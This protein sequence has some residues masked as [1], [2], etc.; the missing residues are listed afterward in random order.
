MVVA[1][2]LVGRNT[3]AIGTEY[4]LLRTVTAGSIKVILV[5][6]GVCRHNPD[7]AFHNTSGFRVIFIEN[8]VGSGD[9]NG[10]GVGFHPVHKCH[11]RED[12]IGMAAVGANRAILLSRDGSL[13]V[14]GSPG[15]GCQHRGFPGNV[16]IVEFAALE[17]AVPT[18]GI[19]QIRGKAKVKD[20]N[21]IR[22]RKAIDRNRAFQQFAAG[23]PSLIA[24]DICLVRLGRGDG[25]LCIGV[26]YRQAG[27]LAHG[28]NGYFLA[29]VLQSVVRGVSRF[30]KNR[31]VR[32]EG[33]DRIGKD[34]GDAPVV[35]DGAGG[36]ADTGLL[37]RGI[38]GD[39][40]RNAV[41]CPG[42]N[43]GDDSRL[44]AADAD[45]A[46]FGGVDNT[47]RIGSRTVGVL[48]GVGQI[49][50]FPRREFIFGTVQIQQDP[51]AK[52]CTAQHRIAEF[53]GNL[54]RTQL[55]DVAKGDCVA[56]G[57]VGTCRT[58][59]KLRS[60][61]CRGCQF[62]V[63]V[64]GIVKCPCGTIVNILEYSV[65]GFHEL[66]R[67]TG[68]ESILR[69]VV[70]EAVGIGVVAD[71]ENIC[72]EYLRV[73]TAFGGLLR[74][75]GFGLTGILV[76]NGKLGEGNAGGV[77]AGGGHGEIIIRDTA[78]ILQNTFVDICLIQ[79]L[80]DGQ[81]GGNGDHGKL[82]GEVGLKHTPFHVEY[83]HVV[84]FTILEISQ[85]QFAEFLGRI[86]GCQNS[87][88]FGIT[89]VQP[90]VI[91]L[92]SIT[93]GLVGIETLDH[94]AVCD[95]AGIFHR[96]G[97]VGKIDC[98]GSHGVSAAHIQNQFAIDKDPN[99]IVAGE[100][101]GDGIAGCQLSVIA[102]GEVDAELGTEAIVDLV[103]G[104]V[105]LVQGVK[106]VVILLVLNVGIAGVKLIIFIIVVYSVI[107]GRIV[108]V[109]CDLLGGIVCHLEGELQVIVICHNPVTFVGPS[110]G[111]CL[112]EVQQGCA[113]DGVFQVAVGIQIAGYQ[114]LNHTGSIDFRLVV[115]ETQ[116]YVGSSAPVAKAVPIGGAN[117][118]AVPGLNE[119][120]RAKVQRIGILVAVIHLLGN[121]VVQIGID[122]ILGTEPF[123]L[124]V[125]IVA[126]C[127]VI[128][129]TVVVQVVHQ[130]HVHVEHAVRGKV[131]LI[132]TVVGFLLTDDID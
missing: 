51:E 38:L 1:L 50:L 90:V 31:L 33:L 49:I 70:K 84:N 67:R 43:A 113:G 8:L 52:G 47:I 126:L 88:L 45:D 29:V 42:R 75:H 95:R 40:F 61:S 92:I 26:G 24:Q 63:A 28:G 27:H 73:S 128:V 46:V 4:E 79:L 58:H 125:G 103:I 34:R 114:P 83:G 80:T 37:P 122:R 93:G 39:D 97:Q 115:I 20:I 118:H 9:L 86:F 116:R 36:V 7:L 110:L 77:G 71:T 89:V 104:I 16:A 59:G 99:V 119:V 127:L 72:P 130:I 15:Q 121:Q 105:R 94:I 66:K 22:S 91:A 82:H 81:T 17:Q 96:S 123:A 21:L 25:E 56:V 98:A 131:H 64:I 108:R 48:Y 112:I 44:T 23:Q 109:G 18:G 100:G 69:V 101:K 85:T 11:G 13:A 60:S 111:C 57:C 87:T 68:N 3:G 5:V 19:C 106:T 10:V 132:L 78:D 35:G 6:D 120:Q 41:G 124:I 53:L 14:A 62:S 102:Y 129:H 107:L 55:H 54:K 2:S 76:G 12:H 74:I 65:G 30:H 117:G 32:R